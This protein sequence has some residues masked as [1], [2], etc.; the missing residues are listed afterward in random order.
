MLAGSATG[1]VANT[2]EPTHADYLLFDLLDTC[3]ALDPAALAP[4]LLASLPA[5]GKWRSG[6]AERPALKAYLGGAG[7][8][9]A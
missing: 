6:L 1:F 2:P 4:K 8:R 9:K 7:R 5:L 3:E